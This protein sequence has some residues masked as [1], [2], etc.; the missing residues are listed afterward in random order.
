MIRFTP[1]KSS[2]RTFSIPGLI[3]DCCHGDTPE[4]V[5]SQLKDI[6]EDL[7]EHLQKEGKE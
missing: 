1:V 2:V 7:V 4:E 3:G 6:A 5:L